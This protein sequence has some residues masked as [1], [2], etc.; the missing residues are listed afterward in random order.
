M[1]VPSV[2]DW[3]AV[4]IMDEL[5]DALSQLVFRVDADVTEHGAGGFG[6]EASTCCSDAGGL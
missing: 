1:I 3:V 2:D 4:E 5:H 6:E